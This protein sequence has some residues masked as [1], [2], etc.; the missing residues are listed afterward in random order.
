[1]ETTHNP[2]ILNPDVPTDP[3]PGQQA[4]MG[5]SLNFAHKTLLDDDLQTSSDDDD[6]DDDETTPAAVGFLEDSPD[7][8]STAPSDGCSSATFSVSPSGDQ[9][10]Y[11]WSPGGGQSPHVT[12]WGGQSPHVRWRVD[13]FPAMA[14]ALSYAEIPA[15]QQQV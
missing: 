8:P 15:W 7:S 6:D 9:Q 2:V 4:S 1:M 3:A 14:L 13:T 10:E 11:C 5:L 12:P